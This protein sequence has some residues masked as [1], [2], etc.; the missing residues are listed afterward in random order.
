MA[1]DTGAERSGLEPDT[2]A[3]VLKVWLED[4]AQRLEWRGYITH[5]ASGRRHP[6]L[7]LGTIGL[8]VGSYLE[9]LGIPLP[10]IWRIRRWLR[11]D[12]D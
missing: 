4:G 1:E 5:V 6:V 3:F 7:R 12:A 10:L 2:H 11:R 8:V 9:Q